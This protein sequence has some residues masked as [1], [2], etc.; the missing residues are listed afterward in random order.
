VSVLRRTDV[1]AAA[2]LAAAA[3]A[4]AALVAVGVRLTIAP[5]ARDWLGFQFPGVPQRIGQAGEIFA[6]NARLLFAV[7]VASMVVQVARPAPTATQVE[8]VALRLLVGLCD[9]V[10]LAAA[11]WHV[12]FVGTAIGAYGHRTLAAMLPHGP[13][14]VSAFALALGLYLTARRESLERRRIVAVAVVSLALL[15]VAALLEVFA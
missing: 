9:I 12:A 10:L 4:L 8:R 3:T 14:E 7:L 11:V 13:F 5:A 6:N 15:A 1:T 2:R